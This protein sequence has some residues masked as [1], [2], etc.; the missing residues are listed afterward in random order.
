[1]LVHRYGRAVSGHDA[2]LRRTVL[3]AEHFRVAVMRS[4]GIASDYGAYME[5][6]ACLGRA[7]RSQLSILLAGRGYFARRDRILEL[8]P[9]SVVESDQAEQEAEGYAGT[10]C[11]VIVLEWG[12]SAP[13]GAGLRGP[14]RVSRL[15]PRD[16]VALRDLVAVVDDLP[17]EAWLPRLWAVLQSTGSPSALDPDPRALPVAPPLVRRAYQELGVALSRLETQPTLTELATSLG[18]GERQTHRRLSDL[19]RQYGLPFEGWR[20]FVHESRLEWAVQLL[21]VPEITQGRVARLAGFG[22]A[23]ALHH[24]LSSRGGRTPGAIARTLRH[25]WG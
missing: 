23:T 3:R 21:S 11:E 6:V 22:S 20:D 12:A 16:V 7:S 5:T 13:F 9:G 24:A 18:L 15:G 4:R 2:M 17:A 10:P 19:L 1:L 8:E 25:R 14:A